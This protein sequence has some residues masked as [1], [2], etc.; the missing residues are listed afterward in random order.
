[1]HFSCTTVAR[2]QHNATRQKTSGKVFKPCLAFIAMILVVAFKNYKLNKTQSMLE[3]WEVTMLF[4]QSLC[5]LVK[6][7]FLYCCHAIACE[8]RQIYSIVLLWHHSLITVATLFLS[9]A[10]VKRTHACMQCDISSTGS[11]AE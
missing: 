2:C 8:W 7:L 5:D 10:C 3:E 4:A 11:V 9:N 6:F 1:M